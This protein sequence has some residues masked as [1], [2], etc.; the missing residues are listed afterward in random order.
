[1]LVNC[2]DHLQY[3]FQTVDVSSHVKAKYSADEVHI[4]YTSTYNTSHDQDLPSHI[5]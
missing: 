3:H 1:M 2:V 4:L 5:L